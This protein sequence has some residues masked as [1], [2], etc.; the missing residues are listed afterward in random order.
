M[1]VLETAS[2]NELELSTYAR[3][4]GLF[5]EQINQWREICEN[6]ND[7]P[8]KSAAELD[9]ELRKCRAEKKQLEREV[10]RKD[11]AL[12]ET[13]ALLTLSKK[14]RAIWGEEDEEE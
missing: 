5:V 1:F 7:K 3:E 2:M 6:A 14:V 9:R 11:K 8:S 4:K 13:A 10:L 12:A